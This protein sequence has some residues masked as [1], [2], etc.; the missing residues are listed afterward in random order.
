MSESRYSRAAHTHDLVIVDE[1]K[2]YED[3]TGDIDPDPDC[4]QHPASECVLR[5]RPLATLT[6]ERSTWHAG[7][8][9][10]LNDE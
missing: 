2:D 6:C 8:G 10:V 4:A 7:C 5:Q 1:A 9:T 3:P